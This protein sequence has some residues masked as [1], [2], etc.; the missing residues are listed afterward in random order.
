MA[1]ASAT[2]GTGPGEWARV[3]GPPAPPNKTIISVVEP[4]PLLGEGFSALDLLFS[5][6][7][8]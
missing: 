2:D 5:G 8:S 6:Q 4:D 3:S 7:R 1:Y